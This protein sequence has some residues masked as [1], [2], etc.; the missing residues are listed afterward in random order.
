MGPLKNKILLSIIKLIKRF[1]KKKNLFNRKAPNILIISTTAL[2]D[3]LWAT[4]HIEAIKKK[5]PSSKL[6][7]LCSKIGYEVLENNPFVDNLFIIKNPFLSPL[8]MLTKLIKEGFGAVLIF[9]A[10]Q[11]VVIAISALLKSEF[12]IATS[13][14]NKGLDSLISHPIERRYVHEVTRREEIIKKLDLFEKVG[15]PTF[16]IKG[17]IPK[18]S[19]KVVIHPGA[20][21]YF[22][23]WQIKNFLSLAK[24]LNDIGYGIS[25]TGTKKEKNLLKEM[26]KLPFCQIFKKNLSINDFAHLIKSSSLLITNDT[27]PLHLADALSVKTIALFVPTDPKR[28][29]PSKNKNNIVIKKEKPCYTC[30]KKKCS[31]PFCFNQITPEEVFKV[32]KKLLSSS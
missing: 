6:S 31:D 16:F 2:G 21:S 7:V 28:F 17:D 5:Y 25:V 23:C 20:S 26:E 19:K 15:R 3:T 8:L 10:S 32:C 12:L 27:G 4:P 13:G 30:I 9:H 1:N 14:L 18:P 11:R 24:M 29:G 22:R